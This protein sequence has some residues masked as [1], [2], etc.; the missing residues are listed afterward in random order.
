MRVVIAEDSAVVREGIARLLRDEGYTVAATVGNADDLLDAVDREH[1]D[2]VIADVRMPPTMT[3]DGA[4]AAEELR[5][6]YPS[7]PIVLLSQ[8]VETVHSVILAASGSFGYLLKDR[9]LEVD[10]FL[11]SLARV[12][13]GGS[14]L[15]PQV[16]ASLV[17][18][19]RRDDPLAALSSREL[20]VL[21]LMAQGKSNG[22]IAT[23]LWLTPRTVESHVRSILSKLQLTDATEGHRRVLA[24]LAYLSA[25]AA[26]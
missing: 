11:D 10:D 14:V 8:H 23:E 9:V 19:T 13:R 25:G 20:N 15:D 22:T 24:V 18:P 2:L 21:E 12:A 26:G 16:V 6:R 4:R 5:H 17:R 1:P 7:L 3:D